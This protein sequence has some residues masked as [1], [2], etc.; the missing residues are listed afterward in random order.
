[1]EYEWDEAKR[2]ATLDERDVDFA[3]M[4]NFEWDTTVFHRSD[5]YGEI[6]LVATGYIG[7]HIYRVVYTERNERRRVISL[8]RASLSE[9]RDYDRQRE[10]RHT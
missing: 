4:H 9:R 10:Q 1:V 5:R 2:R 8:R 6:R 3:W 7:S